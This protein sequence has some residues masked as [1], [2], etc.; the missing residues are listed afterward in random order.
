[1][2]AVGS[3]LQGIGDPQIRPGFGTLGTYRRTTKIEDEHIFAVAYDIVKMS[4]KLEMRARKFV[5]TS[6]IN[7][8]PMRASA[9]YLAFSN[10][11]DEEEAPG[12]DDGGMVISGNK[13][14]TAAQRKQKADVQS[15]FNALMFK[16]S[17]RQRSSA[18]TMN[19]PRPVLI[20]KFIQSR[21]KSESLDI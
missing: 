20:C 3:P 18:I 13:G 9:N 7:A 2:E 4:F 15:L 8:G 11:S 10:D 5:E 21:I 1:M 16:N 6:L 17:L 14:A 19:G 12:V